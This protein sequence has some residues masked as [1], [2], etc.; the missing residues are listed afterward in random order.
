MRR[1]C[2]RPPTPT[3]IMTMKAP[4]QRQGGGIGRVVSEGFA[5]RT[6]LYGNERKPA[7]TIHL[8]GKTRNSNCGFKYVITQLSGELGF[9]NA[10][11]L[12]R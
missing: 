4:R 11:V 3:K 5:W 2:G 12:F 9:H 7:K 10:L 6:M 8:N 1:G